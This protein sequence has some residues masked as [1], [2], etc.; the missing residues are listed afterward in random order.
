M[1]KKN[2]AYLEDIDI[3]FDHISNLCQL[4]KIQINDIKDGL[5]V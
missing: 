3:A 5:P 2:I 4:Y 1:T